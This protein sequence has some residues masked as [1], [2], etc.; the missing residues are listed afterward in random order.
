MKDKL[1]PAASSLDQKNDLLQIDENTVDN[2]EIKNRAKDKL[3]KAASTLKKLLPGHT[4]TGSIAVH[5]YFSELSGPT[6]VTQLH[7]GNT[8]EYMVATSYNRLFHALLKTFDKEME[9]KK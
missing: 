1:S 7:H 3:F 6:Y 9:Q 2:T 5:Y 8:R 4:H